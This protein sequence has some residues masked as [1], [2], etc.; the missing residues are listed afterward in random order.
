MSVF[1]VRWHLWDLV[2]DC[3]VIPQ[4]Q[5]S[6]CWVWSVHST[7]ERHQLYKNSMQIIVLAITSMDVASP[8]YIH[9]HDSFISDLALTTMA[10]IL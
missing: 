3:I 9:T 7:E 8:Q 1:D 4:D 5:L 10:I 2:A 6:C